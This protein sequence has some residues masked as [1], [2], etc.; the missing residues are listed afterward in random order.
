MLTLHIDNPEIEN[1]FHGNTTEIMSALEA[2]ASNR[3][4]LVASNIVSQYVM[5][6]HADV[7]SYK[8]G[9]LSSSS[10]DESFWDGLDKHID[11]IVQD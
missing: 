4:K 8:R 1:Y 6:L 7:Q 5:D 9:E 11:S 2:M 3:A 10:I